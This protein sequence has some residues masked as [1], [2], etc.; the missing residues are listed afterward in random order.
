V[1]RSDSHARYEP[2]NVVASPAEKLP[3]DSGGTKVV[4]KDRGTAADHVFRGL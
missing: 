1:D 3:L 4:R 2:I